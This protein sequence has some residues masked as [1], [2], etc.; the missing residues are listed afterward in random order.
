MES[1]P[2]RIKRSKQRV[3]IGQLPMEIDLQRVDY[4]V[5]NI[6]QS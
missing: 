6:G 2:K 5:V 1:D 3:I 4:R